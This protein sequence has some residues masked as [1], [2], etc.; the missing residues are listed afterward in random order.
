[1]LRLTHN[2][3][4]RVHRNGCVRMHATCALP[5][6]PGVIHPSIHACARMRVRSC[7][8][9]LEVDHKQKKEAYDSAQALYDSRV[10]ALDKE[11]R[12]HVGGCLVARVLWRRCL[13]A[14]V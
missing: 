8:Q 13:C 11:V 3:M 5:C 10:S 12:L 9:E 1:M 6:E 4:P 7:V 2:G 14:H